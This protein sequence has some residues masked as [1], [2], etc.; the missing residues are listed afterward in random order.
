M[1]DN[2][3]IG[4]FIEWKRTFTFE[5]VQKFSIISGDVNPVHLNTDYAA[6]TPFGRPIVHGM[7]VSSLFSG[8]IANEIPG[9]G[10]I[11]L[12]QSLD[13]KAPVFHNTQV[14]ARVEITNIR[15]DKPIFELATICSDVEGNVLIIGKAVVVKK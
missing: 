8:I 7:L 1:Q 12:H 13:F 11:Y 2:F 10:S 5:D 14:I 15:L 4:D 9:P 6:S 3:K